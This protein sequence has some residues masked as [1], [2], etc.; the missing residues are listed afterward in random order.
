MKLISLLT[1]ITFFCTSSLVSLADT[2]YKVVGPD[3]KI[4]YSDKRPIRGN[5]EKKLTFKNLPR[6]QLPAS[7]SSQSATGGTTKVTN[8]A[9]TISGQVT[10]FTAS[11]CGYCKQA[12]AYLASQSINYWEVDIETQDGMAEFSQAG[13]SGAVPLL[14]AGKESLQGFSPEA[15]DDL[16]KRL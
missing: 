6:T 5:V 12:K 8:N 4:T 2:L 3:G 10:L 14:M 1:A 13:D 9:K 16:L 7:A 11:W 15:Y